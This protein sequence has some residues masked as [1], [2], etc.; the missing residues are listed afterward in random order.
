MLKIKEINNL[1]NDIIEYE[2]GGMAKERLV[3]F[4][5]DLANSG[6]LKN[7]QGH[8]HRNF[9]NLINFKLISIKE[10]KY[11]PTT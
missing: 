9:A 11:E 4:Y 2:Q 3:P 7:L 1:V 10:G 6:L 8:Y 5:C